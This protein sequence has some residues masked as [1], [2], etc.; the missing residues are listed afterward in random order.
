MVTVQRLVRLGLISLP[1]IGAT[2]YSRVL[3]ALSW[4]VGWVP[5][6]R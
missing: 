6:R 5:G 2:G 4:L 3:A 1:L